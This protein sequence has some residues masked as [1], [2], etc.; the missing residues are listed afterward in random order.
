VVFTGLLYAASSF[1]SGH[2]RKDLLPA[3]A[4]LSWATLRRAIAHHLRF[5]PAIEE[6]VWSYNLLQRLAYVFVVFGLF[7]LL[8]WTG[9]AM[10]PAITAAFPYFVDLAGGQQ[11]AR[12]IHFFA[13]LSLVFF[14]FVHVL[15]VF[16]SG[17]RRRTRG[18]ITG[19]PDAQQEH[20]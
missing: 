16:L 9:L 8:I 14:F 2:L 20:L 4:D 1:R 7:P 18:M 13:T 11:S 12:T 17:F 5:K 19:R 10:S 6:D 3:A 15:M